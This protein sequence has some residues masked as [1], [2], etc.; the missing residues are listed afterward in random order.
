MGDFGLA[1]VL[2]FDKLTSTGTVLGTPAYMSPEQAR[3]EKLDHRSDIYSLGATYYKSIFGVSP[4]PGKTPVEVAKKHLSESLTF[5]NTAR[6]PVP[7]EI[8]EVLKKTMA[9]D[10]R[11]RY[12][13]TRELVVDLEKIKYILQQSSP[14]ESRT[15]GDTFVGS[16]PRPHS[17]IA[18]WRRIPWR[19]IAIAVVVA[20]IATILGR[21]G[22]EIFHA[23]GDQ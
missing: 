16:L 13:I 21:L 7:P 3:G 2:D 22:Y 10:R 23:L 12:R 17:P 4:F 18:L 8:F 14:S 19:K 6:S 15:P 1:K 20:L 9:K 5:P 11:D